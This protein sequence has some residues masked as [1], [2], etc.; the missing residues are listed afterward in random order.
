IGILYFFLAFLLKPLNSFKS[1][2][3]I[4]LV[5]IISILWVFAFIT[6]L[7]ASVTRA[8]TLFTFIS[9]G[10]SFKQQ[11][12]IFNAVA[13][14]ALLLLIFNPNFIFDVGF[15]LS[16]TAVI[17]ILVFQ[18][19][20][21]KFYFTKHKVGIYFIDIVLVSLAAQIGVLPLSLYY[22]NQ[23]PLLFLIANIVVIPLASFILIAGMISLA[24]NFIYEPLAQLIGKM[25]R[26]AINVMNQYIA[27]IAK[28]ENGIIENI[29]F[30]IVLTLILYLV[31]L[32]FI[33]WLYNLKWSSFKNTVVMMMLFQL[34][35]LITL[36]YENNETELVVFNSK[37]TLV[38]IKNNDK[39]TLFTNDSTANARFIKDYTRGIFNAKNSVET[40]PNCISFQNKR[41]LIVD[42]FSIYQTSL[43]VEIIVLSQ[44]PRIN[45]DRLIK[46]SKPKL[47][48]ADNSNPFYKIKEWG[49]TCEQKKYL[50]MPPPKRDFIG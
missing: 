26:Y 19:F 47:I 25:I 49:K 33:Y 16:Y 15:Q 21:K 39:L 34:A 4:K 5:L 28:V 1:G 17:S 23:L 3:Y 6:G 40:I 14:S 32:S 42:S 46:E 7:P 13:V 37:S 27:L 10:A 43:K 31:I 30:T 2:K 41:I 35:Y 45:L 22:F 44:S 11:N 36:W 50:F 38:S 18:P 48:I 29:S 9:I 8:V 24:L 20:Y 12:N